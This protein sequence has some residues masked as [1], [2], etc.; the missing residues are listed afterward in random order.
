METSTD[1]H[2]HGSVHTAK[3]PRK[4]LLDKLFARIGALRP[5]D[6]FL[7]LTAAGALFVT[8]LWSVLVVDARMSGPISAEA[9]TLVE[10]VVGTP[11]FV[12]PVLAVT[13]ADRDLDA[14]IYAGIARLNEDGEVVPDIAETITVSDDGLIYNVVLRSDVVFHDGEPL[15]AEDV[16]FTISRVQDPALGSPLRAS[17][18]GVKVEVLGEHELNFILQSAYAPFIENLTI[19]I[20]PK[21][22]WQDA[23]NEEFPFS[24]YNSEPIGAGP[25]KVDRVTRDESGIPKSYTLV[26]HT[27]Y[28]RDKAKVQT[29]V[30]DFFTN[31]SK[32]IE[33]FNLGTVESVAGLSPEAIAKLDL[34]DNTHTIVTT[35]LPRTFAVFFN[36]N[37]SAALL[38]EAARN[39]LT[40]AIDRADLVNTVLGGYAVP[41]S[42][43]I[44]P[45]F[46]IEPHE[47]HELSASPLDTARTILRDGGWEVNEETG[48]WEKEIDDVV[49]PLA[50]SISTANAPVFE[51]TA[52]YLANTWNTLGASVG[53]KQFEQSD[54]TQAIIRPRDYEALLFGTD[55]GR[56]LDFYSF[57]HSSQRNDPGLNVSLYAN[58][59]TD[60]ILEKARTSQDRSDRAQAFKLFESELEK[61]TPAVFLYSP[62][63]TYVLPK[64]ITGAGFTGL[65]EP[66]ERFSGVNDWFMEVES[67]WPIFQH[68]N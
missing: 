16:A 42:S 47:E 68:T 51:A 48:I 11:R 55:L 3:R 35:P 37:K 28:H 13:H 46:G 18:D 57:W 45:G 19:G 41:L 15:T 39:A 64:S 40:V 59:T 20:L 56:A 29:I 24:Q 32:L 62:L 14:L 23:S 26:P 63:F 30:L 1:H 17:W 49:T 54:L 53:I 52:E 2:L 60:S 31:E 50:F 5:S 65:A 22:I 44:P 12:N 21:H 7:I 27:E 34:S 8:V 4:P 10:G 58:I 33:A 43:P 61:E 38:D 36:Q 67:V 9:G 6:R 66:Y 25:Y